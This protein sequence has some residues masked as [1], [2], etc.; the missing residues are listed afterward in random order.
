MSTNLLDDIKT[1]QYKDRVI[2]LVNYSRDKMSEEY[3]DR[4]LC[5]GVFGFKCKGT[6]DSFIKGITGMLDEIPETYTEKNKLN[7]TKDDIIL[8][9]IEGD[10]RYQEWEDV[11][12]TVF[13]CIL[14]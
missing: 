11:D 12:M 13:A 10:F 8:L 7:N 1:I 4:N 6:K 5:W 9:M 14:V 2:E 3:K